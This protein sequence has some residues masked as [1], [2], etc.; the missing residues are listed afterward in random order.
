MKYPDDRELSFRSGYPWDQISKHFDGVHHGGYRSDYDRFVY[1]WDCESTA[2][3]DTR[4]LEFISEVKIGTAGN[5]YY[6]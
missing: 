1:G 5:R 2:W 3:L 4:F 6:D